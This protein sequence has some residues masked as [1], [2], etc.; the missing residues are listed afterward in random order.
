M[1]PFSVTGRVPLT[2]RD[3]AQVLA[4]VQGMLD[5]EGARAS[6][7]DGDA[8]TFQND[9]FRQGGRGSVI[10]PYDRGEIRIVRQGDQTW[11]VYDNSLRRI[12][13]VV[14]AFAVLAGLFQLLFDGTLV[15]GAIISTVLW[16][17]LFGP[18]YLMAASRFGDWL[19][20][21]T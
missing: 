9:L 3:D 20:K 6:A 4:A 14:T 13:G 2:A 10:G 12:L 7:I 18:N 8:V 15:A 16:L 11:L 19:S 21:A 17:W 1:F 5:R